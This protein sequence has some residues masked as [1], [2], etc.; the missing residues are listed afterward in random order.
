MT[1]Q[2]Y[3][4]NKLANPHFLAQVFAFDTSKFF[5]DVRKAFD[6]W[7]KRVH[8]DAYH[9]GNCYVADAEKHPN[10]FT[11]RL[12]NI[13]NDEWIRYGHGYLPAMQIWLQKEYCA[14]D[15]IGNSIN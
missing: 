14:E 10:V 15:W 12:V 3:I 5:W 8:T 11:Y 4:L 9:F 6:H 1:N 2:E 7:A 13:G